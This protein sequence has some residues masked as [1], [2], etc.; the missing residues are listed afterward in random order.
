MNIYTHFH[1]LFQIEHILKMPD[2]H[3]TEF[4]IINKIR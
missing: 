3:K 2:P 1:Y 4:I